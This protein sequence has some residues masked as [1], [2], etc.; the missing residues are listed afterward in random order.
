MAESTVVHIGEN[1]PEKIA[2][3]LL[4]DIARMES[5]VL[6]SNPSNGQQIA[7]R[8]WLL[9]TYSE[10]IEAVKGYRRAK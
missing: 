7:T 9:D 10:C 3:V 2:Y 4:C 1:S 8:Q 5:T 6:H